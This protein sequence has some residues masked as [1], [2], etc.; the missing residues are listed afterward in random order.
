MLFYPDT[1]PLLFIADRLRTTVAAPGNDHR[2]GAN[3][4]PP[5]IVS[6][7][8]GE[9]LTDIFTQLANGGPKTSRKG[10]EIK[11][12]VTTLPLLPKDTTDRN[13]TSP[14]AFTG[15][16]FEFR[17]VGSSQSTAGPNFVLNTIVADVLSEIADELEKAKDINAAAQ[18]I[19]RRI[20]NEHSRIIFNGDNYTAEWEAE[21]ERR[22]LP[23]IKNTVDSLATLMDKVHVELFQKHGVL[24][25]AEL[26]AREEILFEN[27]VKT[28]GIEAKTALHIAKRQ[29]IPAVIR[30][31]GMV[32][33]SVS[34][35]KSAGGNASASEAVLGSVTDLSEKLQKAVAGLE[36]IYLKTTQMS[37][38]HK[39]AV[40]VR[41]M[42]I[43]AMN[44]VRAVADALE[45]IVD[46]EVWPLP[47]YAQMLF[48]R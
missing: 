48:M 35:I 3:E 40:A 42:M 17:M 22:G 8:L 26:K 21:A 5:A 11:L 4:A 12:G 13:R 27:Y 43:P 34:A 44:E 23:N 39:R 19:L 18:K 7:F 2:L 9:Q 31:S 45:Q 24:S 32:A 20:A 16:K 46:A 6:I 14:F 28:L 29:I 30:Y 15:N 47:T 36:S 37:D 10:E 38:V 1:L 41:D 25:K 33:S